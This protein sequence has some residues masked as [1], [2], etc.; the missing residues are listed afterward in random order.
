MLSKEQLNNKG[1]L[2]YM[3]IFLKM[4]FGIVNF[5]SM[6]KDNVNKTLNFLR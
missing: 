6:K 1:W 4:L 3:T 5:K 2:N